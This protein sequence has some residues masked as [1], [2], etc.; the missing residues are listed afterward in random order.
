MTQEND[1]VLS[2]LTVKI[3][4]SK[5]LNVIAILSVLDN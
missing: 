2:K 5:N 3:K 1:L 4:D